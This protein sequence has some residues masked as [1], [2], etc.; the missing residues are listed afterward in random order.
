MWH[1]DL[2]PYWNNPIITTFGGVG[3]FTVPGNPQRVI[4]VILPTGTGQVAVLPGQSPDALAG[5]TGIL[6]SRIGSDPFQNSPNHL[7]ITWQLHGCMVQG[8]WQLAASNGV[9]TWEYIWE[10]RPPCPAQKNNGYAQSP[11]SRLWLPLDSEPLGSGG[12]SLDPAVRG[13]GK[14]GGNNPLPNVL[15]SLLNRFR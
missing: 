8:P 15:E 6:L 13:S 1:A 11:K 5:G 7:V 9:Q 10:R 4:L 12:D 3:T 2:Y 14:A